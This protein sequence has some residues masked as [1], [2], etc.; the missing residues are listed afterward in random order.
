MDF[1]T[2]D[3]RAGR[4]VLA[5]LA[6]VALM[7]SGWLTAENAAAGENTLPQLRVSE[8]GRFL[9]TADGQPF[10]W[11]ADTAWQLIHDLDE[12]EMRRYFADR[13]DKGFTVIQTVVLAEHRFERPNAFGHLPIDPRRP[14]RPIVKDGP[15]NDYWDDVQRVLRL[16]EEHGLYVGLLPT[17]GRY[18]TSNWQNGLV[19]GFFT[20]ANADAYALI[21]TPTGRTLD[22]Q[23]G[24]LAGENV[25]SVWF[26]P[27]NGASTP[28]G[29][30][31]NQSRR[32]FD[33]PGDE[34]PGHDW[35]L[36]LQSTTRVAP[37]VKT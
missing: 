5:A 17:W 14:D 32:I 30:F 27:R 8:N 11:L 6:V 4:A 36:I 23:L 1:A 12:A 18:V 13:R 15:D 10:F 28:V 35:V 31:P 3:R 22:I 33:P 2:H 16:A 21:Y 34:Q 25:K 24:K 19:D 37:T 29:E 20:V 26:D 9:V 7:V